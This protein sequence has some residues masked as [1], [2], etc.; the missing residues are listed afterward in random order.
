V[1]ALPLT[2]HSARRATPSRLE[3]LVSPKNL[4]VLFEIVGICPECSSRPHRRP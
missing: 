4:P 3:G 2:L 1:S